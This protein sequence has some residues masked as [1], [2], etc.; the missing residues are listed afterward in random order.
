[1]MRAMWE[2]KTVE[3]LDVFVQVYLYRN[4]YVKLKYFVVK[5]INIFYHINTLKY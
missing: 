2:T 1:M 4:E 3:C 5:K